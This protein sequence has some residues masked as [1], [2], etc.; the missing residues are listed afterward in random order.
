[1]KKHFKNILSLAMAFSFL[2]CSLTAVTAAAAEPAAG[3]ATTAHIEKALNAVKI[4]QAA[5]EAIVTDAGSGGSSAPGDPGVVYFGGN[6][7][8]VVGVNQN[9]SQLTLYAKNP[10]LFYPFYRDYQAREDGKDSYVN[11]YR[12]SDIFWYLN[13]TGSVNNG[14]VG[15]YMPGTRGKDS[16][17]DMSEPYKYDGTKATTMYNDFFKGRLVDWNAMDY[18]TVT[19]AIFDNVDGSYKSS[20]TTSAKLFLPSGSSAA[21]ED[22]IISAG[23]NDLAHTYTADD[24]LRIP[25]AYWV[26]AGTEE[27]NQANWLRSAH[28]AP[29]GS[30]DMANIAYFPEGIVTSNFVD[31]AMPVAPALNLKLPSLMF[32]SFIAG[33][34]EQLSYPAGYDYAAAKDDHVVLTLDDKAGQSVK[35]GAFVANK[36]L[37]GNKLTFELTNAPAAGEKIGVLID[38]GADTRLFLENE[39]TKDGNKYTIPNIGAGMAKAGMTIDILAYNENTDGNYSTS[40][41][42]SMQD[43]A[44]A[45]DGGIGGGDAVPTAGSMENNALTVNNYLIRYAKTLGNNPETTSPPMSDST[46]AAP[47]ALSFFIGAA[48]LAAMVLREKQLNKA[49]R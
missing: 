4:D 45:V 22:Q 1:M 34:K 16:A 23:A 31:A 43:N 25:A 21:G 41:A 6:E 7:Y 19:N 39:L 12:D 18:T 44:L 30:T 13:N 46:A 2:F 32:A 49:G 42:S 29:D 33:G 35:T 20:Y 40:T 11:N 15:Y 14:A 10:Y 48:A 26:S 28:S 27:F 5:P 17:E 3:S 47:L 8:W 38:N 24:P 37:E 36:Q 9:P